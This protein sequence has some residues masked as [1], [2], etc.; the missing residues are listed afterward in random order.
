MPGFYINLPIGGAVAV[1]L[2]LIAIPDLTIKDASTD[3]PTFHATLAKLDLLGFALFAPAA[4]QFL[5]A[6]EWGGTRYAWS[7]STIIGLFCGAVGTFAIFIGWEYRKGEA[8]MIPLSMVRQKVVAFSC[9]VIFFL[10]GATL[11]FSYYLPIYFQAVR[12]V[13]PTLSG[14]YTLPVILSQMVFAILSGYLG[15]SDI[16]FTSCFPAPTYNIKFRNLATIFS[17]A[18]LAES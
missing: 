12:G 15:A 5:L 9:I 4:I 7:S 2:L 13:T 1:L 8:A 16:L 11:T 17:G 6:L 3:K 14:V 10:F 18:L